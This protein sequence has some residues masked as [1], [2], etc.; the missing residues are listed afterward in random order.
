MLLV[1]PLEPSSRFEIVP[2]PLADQ[3]PVKI[4]KIV[5]VERIGSREARFLR[6]LDYSSS[7][8]VDAM[9]RRWTIF[10]FFFFFFLSLFFFFGKAIERRTVAGRDRAWFAQPW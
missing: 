1:S 7:T 4:T 10:F 2:F 9:D 5:V 6:S 8:L 3:G